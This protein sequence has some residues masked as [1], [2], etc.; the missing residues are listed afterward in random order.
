MRDPILTD[1]M[2]QMNAYWV[3][4]DKRWVNSPGLEAPQAAA[5]SD[6]IRR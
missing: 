6:P 4:A 3:S 1:E 2:K 5:S